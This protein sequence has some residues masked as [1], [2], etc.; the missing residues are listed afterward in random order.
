MSGTKVTLLEEAGSYRQIRSE[1][2]I[3]L[4][5]STE[6]LQPLGR[7][8][9]VYDKYGRTLSYDIEARLRS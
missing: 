2:G 7:D 6:S 3:E 8:K 1:G 5:V 4:Y 9:R